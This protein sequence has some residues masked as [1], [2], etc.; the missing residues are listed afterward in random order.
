MDEKLSDYLHFP[1]C[2]GVYEITKR[3]NLQKKND[4]FIVE[5]L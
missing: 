5:K 1:S 4:M 2:A 3:D